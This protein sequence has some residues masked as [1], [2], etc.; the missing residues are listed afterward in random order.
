DVGRRGSA[1]DGSPSTAPTETGA[2]VRA[3][4]PARGDRDVGPLLLGAVR[5]YGG[6][7]APLAAA[8]GDRRSKESPCPVPSSATHPPP[9]RAICSPG[10]APPPWRPRSW[11]P[12]TSAGRHAPRRPRR[13]PPPPRSCSAPRTPP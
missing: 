7:R 1:R 4:P 6:R 11:A 13:A 12:S 3:P 9:G 8:R 5:G 10:P 2:A